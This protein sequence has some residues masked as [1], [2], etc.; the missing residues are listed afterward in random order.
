MKI[1]MV[2]PSNRT[3]GADP[4]FRQMA[5][6]IGLA[7]L[8]NRFL[9]WNPHH[10]RVSPGERILLPILDVLAGKT[11]LYRVPDRLGATDVAVLV[12]AGRRPED[13]PYNF[14]K[15]F[16]PASWDAPVLTRTG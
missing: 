11:P 13:R 10:Y 14:T 6:E 2:E 8:M 7:S 3:V 1:A 5:D 15:S 12:E 16:L 4:I 9:P